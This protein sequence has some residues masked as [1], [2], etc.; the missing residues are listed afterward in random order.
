MT[1][2]YKKERVKINHVIYR[3]GII[4]FAYVFQPSLVIVVFVKVVMYCSDVPCDHVPPNLV[5]MSFLKL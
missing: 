2:R 4:L 3:N 1:S 5:Y